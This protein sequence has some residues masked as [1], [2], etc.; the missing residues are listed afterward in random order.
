MNNSVTKAIFLDGPTSDQ[1][2]ITG[3]EVPAWT[4]YIGDQD[5]DPID[6]R[7][8]HIFHDYHAARSKARELA[9]KLRLRLVNE[10]T[11]D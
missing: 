1:D 9:G 8:V 5:A 4:V 7:Q 10:A 2:P 3:E 6:N 11:P